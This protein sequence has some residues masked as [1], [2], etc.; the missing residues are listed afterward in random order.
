MENKTDPRP[1]LKRRIR[2][3]AYG[4]QRLA[5][6]WS[7]GGLT[8]RRKLIIHEA[9]VATKLMYGL[10]TAALPKGWEDRIDAAFM[11][12]I[13]QILNLK[14]TYGQMKEGHERTKITTSS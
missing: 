5:V 11:K 4:R 3:A 1:E 6:F 13:R 10:E 2:K 8:K 12:G 7:N 14:T 9:L